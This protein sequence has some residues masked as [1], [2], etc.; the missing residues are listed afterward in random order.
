MILLHSDSRSTAPTVPFTAPTPI[1]SLLLGTTLALGALAAQAQTAA[2]SPASPMSPPSM[3][4]QP[5]AP[6]GKATDAVPANKTD[7][8]D[9]AAAFAKGDTNKDGKL[10]REEIER[11]PEIASRFDQIDGNKDGFL[12]REEFSKAAGV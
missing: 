11:Y 1:R 6:A 4:A 12:S 2:P 5:P 9:V 10:S 7:A 3:A 8:K